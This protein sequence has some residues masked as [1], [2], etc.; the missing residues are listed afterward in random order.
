MRICVAGASG[1]VGVSLVRA[2]VAPG[3]R[4][5]ALTR[6]PQRQDELR[7][8]GSTPAVAANRLRIDPRMLSTQLPLSNARARAALR[9]RPMFPTFGDGLAKSFSQ[10]A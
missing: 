10:A 6:S 2:L 8:L 9:W 1:T 3:H 5:M 4:V 7:R